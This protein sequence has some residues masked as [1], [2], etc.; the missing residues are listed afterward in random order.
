MGEHAASV[1]VNL[2]KGGSMV[3]SDEGWG[4]GGGG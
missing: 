3:V 1:C 2:M 4:G